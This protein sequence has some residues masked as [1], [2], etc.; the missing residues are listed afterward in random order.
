MYNR[1]YGYWVVD[2]FVVSIHAP[3]QR[4]TAVLQLAGDAGAGKFQRDI[5]FASGFVL[6]LT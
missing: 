6:R 5:G 1:P 2:I 3:L 4:D